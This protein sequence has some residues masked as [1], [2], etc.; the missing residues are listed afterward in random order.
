M[1]F[2]IFYISFIRAIKRKAET[3]NELDWQ[4]GQRQRNEKEEGKE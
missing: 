1:Y 3:L 4:K 2:I